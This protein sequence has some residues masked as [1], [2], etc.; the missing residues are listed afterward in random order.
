MGIY[1]NKAHEYFKL[2]K[3]KKEKDLGSWVDQASG[4]MVMLLTKVGME[5]T[6]F[7]LILISG[8]KR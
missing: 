1:I 2:K 5:K 3:K 7:A 4:S 6:W 8:R